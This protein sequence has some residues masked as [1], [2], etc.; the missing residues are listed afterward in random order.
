MAGDADEFDLV[1][2]GSGPGGYI[3]AIRAAQLGLKVA[4]VEKDST[5]GGTCLNIG[6]IPSKAIL[7]SSFL[8]YKSMTEMKEHGV[9]LESVRLDLKKMLERKD[10]VVKTLTGGVALLFNK[11][12]IKTIYGRGSFQSPNEIVVT[13]SKNEKT[14]IKTKNVMI[15][16]GSVPSS[17]PGVKIDEDR[18]VSSTGALSLP[19]VPKNLIVIGGGYIGLELGSVWSRLGSHVEVVEFMDRIIPNMDESLSQGLLKILI[20]QGLNFNFKTAVQSVEVVGPVVKVTVKDVLS[21]AI[22]VMEADR[23]LVSVGR[24][25]FI[26]GLGLDKIGLTPNAKGFI[27]VNKNFQTKLKNVYAVGDVIGGLMLAHKAEE[28]GVA[29][30]EIITGERPEVNYNLVPGVLY[31]HPEVASVG[32]TEAE[33]KTAGVAY[34]KGQFNLRANGRAISIGET[35]GFVKILADEKTDV[36]LGVHIIAPNASEMIHELCIAME[37]GATSEDIALT[38]HGHP[39]LSE[40]VKEAA[41]NVHGRSLNS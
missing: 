5:L 16:T 13:S 35:E 37:F 36:V 8:Y 25:P 34:K 18:V 32:K 40:S 22:Q 39:T 19:E 23:V 41:L 27:E 15:A 11:N 38:M 6:C 33:L 31:T 10:K 20:K 29:C 9:L 28:E 17:L 30:A 24:K 7:E 14:V 1:V 21:G 2:I 4:C 12:K 26:E 3:G